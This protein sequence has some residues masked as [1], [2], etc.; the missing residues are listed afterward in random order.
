MSIH[1]LGH[2]SIRTTDLDASRRFYT[3]VLGMKEGFRPP[4]KFPGIWFYMGGDE[5]DYGTVHIIGIDLNDKQGLVDYLGDKPADSL[6]GTGTVDHVAFLATGLA[7]MRAK[8]QSMEIRFTERTVPSLGLH[9]VFINDPS[10]V[11]IELNYPAQ[12]AI[13]LGLA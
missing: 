3:A 4:F 6:K 1:K 7:E 11:T 2:Y 13:T 9:Q 10:D 5:S 8:L 12:E